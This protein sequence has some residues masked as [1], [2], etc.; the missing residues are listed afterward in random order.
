M[1]RAEVAPVGGLGGQFGGAHGHAV[2]LDVVGVPVPA[3]RVVGDEHLR[4]QLADHRDEVGGGL[5]DVGGQKAP[6]RRFC[7]APIMPESR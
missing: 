4:A 5:V 6:G 2:G 3:V 1:R 7:G